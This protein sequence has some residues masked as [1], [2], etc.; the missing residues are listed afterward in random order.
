MTGTP[1]TGRPGAP[2]H[3]YPLTSPVPTLTARCHRC[4]K[5]SRLLLRQ[6]WWAH[7]G[8]LG[9]ARLEGGRKGRAVEDRTPGGGETFMGGVRGGKAEPPWLSGRLHSVGMS[10]QSETV[11]LFGEWMEGDSLKIGWWTKAQGT[12]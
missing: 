7:K 6:T 8:S 1:Q 5:L 12:V 2:D 9:K 4:Q 3:P 10:E 11:A